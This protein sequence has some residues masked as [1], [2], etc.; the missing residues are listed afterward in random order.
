MEHRPVDLV[1]D[2]QPNLDQTIGAHPEDVAV[3][4]GMMELAQGQ[5]VRDLRVSSRI[6]IGHDV[7]G[8]QHFVLAQATNRA[9]LLIGNEHPLAKR[10]LVESDANLTGDVSAANL[11]FLIVVSREEG[12]LLVIDSNGER[13]ARWIIAHDVDRPGI[14][15][16]TRDQPL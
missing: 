7:S 3:E 8:L 6:A 14:Q 10:L 9:M 5:P 16:P 15:I 4:R 2:I 1:Q 12:E 11:G 13:Q